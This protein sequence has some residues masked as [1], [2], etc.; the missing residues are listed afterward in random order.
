VTYDREDAKRIL[1]KTRDEI[2]WFLTGSIEGGLELDAKVKSVL[3]VAQWAVSIAVATM[4]ATEPGG[5]IDAIDFAKK[6]LAMSIERLKVR[7]P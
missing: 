1:L 6:Q 2:E 4:Q 5:D 7:G 3:R